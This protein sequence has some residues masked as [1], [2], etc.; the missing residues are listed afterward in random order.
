MYTA[1]ASIQTKEDDRL[2]LALAVFREG[3]S[4]GSPF[5]GFIAFWNVVEAAFAGDESCRDDFLRT[6]GPAVLARYSVERELPD[7]DAAKYLKWSARNPLAHIIREKPEQK[8]L[9]PDD[10]SDRVQ[11]MNDARWMQD[12]A[13]LAIE[14]QWPQ[15]VSTTPR[16]R[17]L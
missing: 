9:N 16:E 7:G 15:P 14:T 12:L 6:H 3:L 13:H 8:H 1:P 10:P 5:L 2:R 4:T 11:L 17:G